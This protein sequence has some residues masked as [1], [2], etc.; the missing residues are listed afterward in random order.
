MI[1]IRLLKSMSMTGHGFI[2]FPVGAIVTPT[3][4]NEA[5]GLVKRGRAEY[6]TDEP[7]P[8]AAPAK[9]APPAKPAKGG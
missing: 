6:V 5:H 4:E 8:A 2:P 9:P 1:K 3:T 7:V